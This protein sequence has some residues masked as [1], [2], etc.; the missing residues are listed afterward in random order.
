M[1]YQRL[2]HIKC[3]TEFNWHC[4]ENEHD[5][6]NYVELSVY[7]LRDFIKHCDLVWC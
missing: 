4:F 7:N 1:F 2:N 3:Q 5:R 6:A